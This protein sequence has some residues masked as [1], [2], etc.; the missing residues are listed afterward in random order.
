MSV[1]LFVLCVSLLFVG[2]AYSDEKKLA[3]V[4]GLVNQ[5]CGTCHYVP[6]PEL[7][8]KRSWPRVIKFMSDLAD[9]RAGQEL[10]SETQLSDITAYYYGSSPEELKKL[11]YVN[12]F[13]PKVSL[14]TTETGRFA[15]LPLIIKITPVELSKSDAKEFLICD[16]E[17]DTVS[18][19][20]IKGGDWQEKV[21]ADVRVPSNAVV[22]DMDGDGDLDIVVAALGL[23]FPPTGVY[24]GRVVILEQVKPGEFTKHTVLENVGRVTDAQP[25]DM[26]EDG[27]LDIAISVFG[28]D[29][30]GEIAWLENVG[31]NKPFVKRTIINVGGGLNVSPIDLNGDGKL[32]LVSFLTQ[33]YEHIIALVNK[34]KGNYEQVVLFQ[35]SSPIGG[36]TSITFFDIDQDG[37]P[38]ILFTNGDAHDLQHDPK[39]YHGVQWLENKG[40]FSFIYHEVG[41]FYGA[42]YA[43][44]G[45]LDG[46]GDIDIVA[47]SWN[48]FWADDKRQTLIWYENEGNLNFTSRALLN[49]PASI[50]AFSL[51]DLNDDNKLDILAGFFNVDLLKKFIN[52]LVDSKENAA[53]L[54][55]N[56]PKKPRIIKLEN[57]TQ[58]SDVHH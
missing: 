1:R 15:K 32:D 29:V 5:F 49:K 3:E 41:R 14:K 13:D 8:P 18:L 16:G 56:E 47:S 25:V 4:V 58:P 35:A 45:D 23:F 28:G 20:S 52:T 21:L 46:D 36:P 38:D 40:S 55:D 53:K 19:A 43:E 50:V 22:A 39:P 31:K 17:S 37:D 2:A 11:P 44:A 48:N 10:L 26:D 57:I 6:S 24:A 33:E 30:P 54:L 51:R 7:L 12:E 34:G 9:E 27:D 42:S